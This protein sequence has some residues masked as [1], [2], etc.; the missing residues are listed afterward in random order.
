M[1]RVDNRRRKIILLVAVIMLIAV[2]A[3]VLTACNN[4]RGT[5]DVSNKGN[6]LEV[7]H[8]IAKFI[9]ILNEGIGNFGWT[10]VAFTVILKLILSPLDIWQKI[11]ARKNS[12]AME[13]M[14][15]QLEAM[16]EK[17][18]DDK[19]RYQQEQMALYKKEKYSMLGSCLPTI[20][21]LVVFIII[22]AGFREMVGWKFA[23]DYQ[24]CY[25]V[26][27]TAMTAELGEEWE[28]YS[29]NAELFASAKDAAQT[30]VYNYYYAD[31]QVESRSFL[32]IKNVFVPDS[33]KTA[34]PDYLTVTGQ[35]GFATSKMV[36]VQ[37]NEYN[38]VMGKVLGTGGWNEKNGKWNG[39]LLL[40]ILS[41]AVSIL[42]QKLLSKAQGTPPPAANGKAADS[43]QANMKMMQYMMP[44]MIGVFAVMY[45][46]AFALYMLM[47]SIC[48]VVF[49][50]G[51]NL[52][53]KLVD[54]RQAKKAGI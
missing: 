44:I 21:T 53:G 45:S 39:W 27:D 42:S 9:K 12:K 19:Q 40:P 2:L 37:Q 52:I 20:V 51:F 5:Y 14:K 46:S 23:T 49:Q 22:F 30:K 16:Q 29:D 32:W 38:D 36:G 35:S 54:A 48:S 1:A 43:M 10:V 33:W 17:Y 50:V 31:E 13:R 8:F 7:T 4:D 6:D 47:S 11:I 41:I 15:P 25:N 34:V 26:Y 18:G 24:N 28:T 3:L